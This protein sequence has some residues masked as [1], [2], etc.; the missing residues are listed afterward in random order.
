MGLTNSPICERC[1]EKDESV[2][3]IIDNCEAIAYSRFRHLVHYFMGPGDYQDAPVRYYTSSEVWGWRAEIE[4][5]AQQIY[6][7]SR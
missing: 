6:E 3:H 5:D 1:L 2:P 7:T 4:G